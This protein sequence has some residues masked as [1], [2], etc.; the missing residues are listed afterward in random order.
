MKRKVAIIGGGITGSAACSRLSKCPDLDINIFD[1]GRRGVGGRT[2]SRK[3]GVRDGG[4]RVA[5]IRFDHGCQFF[6]ADTDRFKKIVNEW[7]EKDYVSEWNGDFRSSI[8]QE[9][10]FFGL[11]STPPFYVSNEADGMQTLSKNILSEARKNANVRLHIGVRVAQLNRDTI[12]KKWKLI[13]TSGEA[14][15]HDTDEKLQEDEKRNLIGEESGYDA[16]I[17]TDISSSFG[18]WHRASA[19]VPD[20]FSTAVRNRVGARVPLLTA[21]IAFD[22]ATAIPFD[23]ASFDHPVVWFAAKTSS[24]PQMKTD[25]ECW[26]IVSTASYACD[27]IEETPMQDPKTG[28]FIPQSPDYLTSVP[29]PDLLRA[30]EEIVC[31][32]AGILGNDALNNLPEHVFMDAQRW[33]S[34]L[35][36][37]RHLRHESSTRKVLSGVPYDSGLHPL[38]PTR[39]EED[40]KSFLADDDL[41]LYQAGDMMSNYTPGMEGAALSGID[42]AE[43]LLAQLGLSD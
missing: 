9:H 29:G 16:V 23:A 41:A 37:H 38:A 42:A 12:T 8:K 5:T 7:I 39:I 31:D 15:Y 20:S 13:G 6:R 28:E 33:G 34:A 19:G 27:K 14:A 3:Y 26:T 22:T 17:L 2:S 10:E 11:P 30:F 36:C 35:P 43:H 4:D 24:K 18:G 21:M 25:K 40:S 32:K 1:Q